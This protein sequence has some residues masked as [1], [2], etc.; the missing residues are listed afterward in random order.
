MISR[1]GPG[2]GVSAMRVI[3]TV[4]LGLSSL[5]LL[6]EEPAGR[7][8]SWCLRE[9][10]KDGKLAHLKKMAIFLTLVTEILSS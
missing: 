2:A 5:A 6:A 4:T 9:G 10:C 3:S 8:S 7:I 1:L